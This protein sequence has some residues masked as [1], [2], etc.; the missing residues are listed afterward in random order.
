MSMTSDLPYRYLI[1]ISHIDIASYF[2]TLSWRP[3]ALAGELLLN[4]GESQDLAADGASSK[5]GAYTRRL[6]GST[7]VHSA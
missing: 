5:A 3:W 2:V 1:S 6:V 4:L 7:Q